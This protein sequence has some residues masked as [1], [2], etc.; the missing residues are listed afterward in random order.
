MLPDF[1]AALLGN[2]TIG[3]H[4]IWQDVA[5]QLQPGADADSYLCSGPYAEFHVWA[6]TEGDGASKYPLQVEDGTSGGSK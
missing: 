6:D 4:R 1:S 3:G 2:E 5:Y